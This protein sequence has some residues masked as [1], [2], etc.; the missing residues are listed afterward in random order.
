MTKPRLQEF[1]ECEE[2]VEGFLPRCE[3]DEQ[4]DVAFRACLVPQHG[5]E[6]GETSYTE[7]EHV[8]FD[9]VE[10]RLHQFAS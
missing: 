5:P 2:A 7:A 4:V 9:P 3:L 8:G 10:S 6:E 1:A